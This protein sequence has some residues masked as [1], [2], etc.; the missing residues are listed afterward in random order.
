MA[1]KN[2]FSFKVTKPDYWCLL[3]SKLQNAIQ[4][5]QTGNDNL[6]VITVDGWE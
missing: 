4:K 1:S 3:S 5:F 2:E 6:P